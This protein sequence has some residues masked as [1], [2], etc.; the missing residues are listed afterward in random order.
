MITLTDIEIARQAVLQPIKEIGKKINLDDNLLEPFGHYKAK[1]DYTKLK[2]KERKA[3]L[4]LV[5]A[6]NP[7]PAGE[8]KTTVSIGLGDALNL[9]NKKSQN[10][11]ALFLFIGLGI[12]N[13]LFGQDQSKLLAGN[14]DDHTLV[15]FGSLDQILQFINALLGFIDLLLN[16]FRFSKNITVFH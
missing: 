14:S 9:I 1:I 11:L 8:G 10:N 6:I 2:D 12:V 5:T 16:P 3:K 7:T 15:V 4:V 13:Y